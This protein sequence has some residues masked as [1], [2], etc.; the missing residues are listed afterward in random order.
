[1][2]SAA[3]RFII[4]FHTDIK[5]GSCLISAQIYC[6][7]TG[8]DLDEA[9]DSNRPMHFVHSFSL[10]KNIV[11]LNKKSWNLALLERSHSLLLEVPFSEKKNQTETKPIPMKWQLQNPNTK[12]IF[13][14]PKIPNFNKG[15]LKI[16]KKYQANTKTFG[17]EIPNTDLVLIFSWY[18]YQIFGFRLT[19]LIV[20]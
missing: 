18:A 5:L 16:P 12:P 13:I 20:S 8:Q 19:S 1:M 9:G 3:L 15:F 17:T 14:L 10:K 4:Y 2:S 6:S 11:S 7:C